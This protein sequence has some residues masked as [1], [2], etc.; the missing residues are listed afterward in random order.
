M[1]VCIDISG[2]N[3]KKLIKWLKVHFYCKRFA[4]RFRRRKPSD[5]NSL[6][7]KDRHSRLV[8]KQKQKE[9][10]VWMIPLVGSAAIRKE[11]L[12]VPAINSISNPLRIQ[13]NSFPAKFRRN[14]MNPL[15]LRKEIKAADRQHQTIEETQLR[16]L[17]LRLEDFRQKIPNK[18]LRQTI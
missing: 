11:L 12:P 7:K 5:F 9:M 1:S 2:Y 15:K 4:M 18:R 10:K 14:K 16:N 6:T 8:R 17:R 13:L 3:L